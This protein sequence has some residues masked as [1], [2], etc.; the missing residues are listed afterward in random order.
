MTRARKK[1]I[2]PRKEPHQ[3][4]SIA[5]VDAI[6]QAAAY[7]LIHRGW[8]AFTTNAVAERAGVNIAS[9][10][11]YFPNKEAIVAELKRRHGA[12][13]ERAIGA[14]FAA[15]ATDPRDQL[16]RVILATLRQHAVEPALHRVL[17]EELP[18]SARRDGLEAAPPW[19][20]E[21]RV[22]L[23]RHPRPE[24]AMLITRTCIHAVVHEAT[25]HQPEL[26]R[27]EDLADELVNL[28]SPYLGLESAAQTG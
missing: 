21:A 7:I 22:L 9:L 26:T 20:D 6:L 5:T 8:G 10:Y 11:Q 25:F 19:L 15:D 16:R 14:V 17:E 23:S 1:S 24:L 13:V 4:R 18:L 28:L 12:E 27:G 3:Q 2:L